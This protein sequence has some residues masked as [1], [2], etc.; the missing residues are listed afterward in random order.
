MRKAIV[1]FTNDL[2]LLD[3]EVLNRAVSENDQ[4]IPV[5]CIDPNL[6][7]KNEFGLKRIDFFRV[8]FLFQSLI[9][10]DKNLRLM[11]SGL[12][13]LIG[14]PEDEIPAMALEFGVQQL[15]TS[16]PI[17]FDELASHKRLK[18]E[19]LTLNC[20]L[21]VLATQTLCHPDD[22]PF[23]IDGIPEVF[24]VFRKKVEAS[25]RIRNIFLK[26]TSISSPPM[27]EMKLPS[28][29]DLQLEIRP[30]DLRAV[31]QCN[32][33]ETMAMDRLNTYFF[34]TKSIHTYKQTRNGLIGSN[35]SSKFSPWLS[36]G[37]LSPRVIYHELKR[38]EAING[39]N[40]STYWLVFELLWRDFFYFM[41]EKHPARYFGS[42]LIKKDSDSP[43]THENNLFDRWKDGQ[44][45]NDFIN[46]NMLELKH[47]GFMSNRGRQ[48][49]ASYFC[50]NMRGDWRLGAAYFEEQLIDYDVSSNWGNWAYIAGAGNNPRGV[51]IFNV[52]KQANEYDQ[53]HTYRKLWL[54][55]I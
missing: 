53:N 46:A 10:L 28:F 7:K 14:N 16:K 22:L 13:V 40:E 9:D 31:C 15:Y 27:G 11:G 47:T 4:I 21:H 25:F 50:H 2:R 38:Y 41:M 29:E 42:K 33:G 35:C 48:V 45:D 12:M 26:P 52:E 23:A 17:G 20:R 8:K 43:Y 19:L 54:N 6:F 44:T 39:A 36:L 51:S 49:V 34:E 18:N 24:T 37:C 55:K 30:Q 5:Y 1:W 3:N 32:G